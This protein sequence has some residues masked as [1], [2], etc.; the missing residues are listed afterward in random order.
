MFLL[1]I[2]MSGSMEQDQDVLMFLV[3]EQSCTDLYSCVFMQQTLLLL[4]CCSN[5]CGGMWVMFLHADT[6]EWC[7][8]AVTC[9]S[10]VCMLTSLSDAAWQ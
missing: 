1:S 2:G 4:C 8:L 7:C 9:G 10:C 3:S 5:I 6:F